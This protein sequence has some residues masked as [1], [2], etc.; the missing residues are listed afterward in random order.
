MIGGWS[1]YFTVNEAFER[2][3]GRKYVGSRDI[4]LGFHFDPKWTRKEFENSPFSKAVTKIQAMGFEA[5]S[6]RFVKRYHASE[7]RELTREESRRLPQYDIFNLYID[8]LVDSDDPKRFRKAGFSVLEEPLLRGVFAG[9]DHVM[10]KVEKTDVL[11]PAPQLL[12]EMKVK[13]FPRRTRDDK[14]TKDLLDLCALLVYSG[15]EPRPI[16]KTSEGMKLKAEYEREI[17][18]TTK[19]EWKYV[20]TTLDISVSAAKRMARLIK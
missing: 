8:V 15:Y 5:E 4:D 12:M 14:K 20:A 3:T 19:E 17:S 1:V 10:T 18:N 6:F 2:A 16:D 11:M 13:S 7:N 9:K